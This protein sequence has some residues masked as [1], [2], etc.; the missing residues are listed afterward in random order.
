MQ[1]RVFSP[2]DSAQDEITPSPSVFDTAFDSGLVVSRTATT[3]QRVQ[4]QQHN[5]EDILLGFQNSPSEAESHDSDESGSS[6][7]SRPTKKRKFVFI[8]TPPIAKYYNRSANNNG[9]TEFP[10]KIRD[11]HK[12]AHDLGRDT[13][14]QA[15]RVVMGYPHV[16]EDAP[17]CSDDSYEFL[18]SKELVRWLNEKDP[19]LCYKSL[20]RIAHDGPQNGSSLS[21]K[22][23][24][25]VYPDV[26]TWENSTLLRTCL[27]RTA[28]MEDLP[29]DETFLWYLVKGVSESIYKNGMLFLRYDA[30]MRAYARVA[31]A[32]ECL[33][34][35][36]IFGPSG[37]THDLPARPLREW[38]CWIHLGLRSMVDGDQITE[39]EVLSVC[40]NVFCLVPVVSQS[41][42]E[43]L[44]PIDEIRCLWYMILFE[45]GYSTGTPDP[46]KVRQA[47]D[48]AV[49]GTFLL[50]PLCVGPAWRVVPTS[51][52]EEEAGGGMGVS[53]LEAEISETKL[54]SFQTFL[55]MISQM[56]YMMLLKKSCIE[57]LWKKRMP[58]IADLC[59][60][61][62][63][64][65]LLNLTK[66][67]RSKSYQIRSQNKI[68]PVS[69][70]S[71]LPRSTFLNSDAESDQATKRAR[72]HH[73]HNH[74]E[75]QRQ[76][77]AYRSIGAL[78]TSPTDRQC[79]EM[80][81]HILDDQKRREI[82]R[83]CI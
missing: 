41:A 37:Q 80:S 39:T 24:T 62:M 65:V 44:S 20:T 13:M 60:A 42:Y 4:Q 70:D 51:K 72:Y 57:R 22:K 29:T 68:Y 1:S 23:G 40:N 67:E 47:S 74:H 76:D 50:H 55:G 6:S 66:M 34:L 7:R 59:D 58:L 26:P 69:T 38:F 36:C 12:V 53:Q 2:V 14:F 48:N 17:G 46:K 61:G 35:W 45:Q 15:F 82:K 32:R 75:E 73:H 21:A 10:Q 8:Q 33:D 77:A 52:E 27:I 63:K 83:F 25:V 56:H 5:G 18:L 43:I 9:H 19:T 71:D 64:D 11:Q 31:K 81:A 49:S 3:T 28:G 16:L 78:S 30:C 54:I 79:A